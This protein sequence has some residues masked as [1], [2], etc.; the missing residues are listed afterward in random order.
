MALLL[1]YAVPL[2]ADQLE[3]GRRIA[4][5]GA[6]LVVEPR[7]DD[8]GSRVVGEQ[9]APRIARAI[10]TVLGASSYR[11]QA[12]RIADE[13]TDNPTVDEVLARL[14]EGSHLG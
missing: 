8:S 6:G 14:L 3:N 4:P 1:I 2:F 5:T 12:G 9:D 7:P 13:M 10:V 11:R